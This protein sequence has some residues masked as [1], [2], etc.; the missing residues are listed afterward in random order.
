M[1]NKKLTSNKACTV[2]YGLVSRDVITQFVV[3]DLKKLKMFGEVDSQQFVCVRVGS[4]CLFTRHNLLVKGRCRKQPYPSTHMKGVQF[5]L[6]L[7][8]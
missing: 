2:Y 7:G 3:S 4:V 5:V 6:K 8:H 1:H